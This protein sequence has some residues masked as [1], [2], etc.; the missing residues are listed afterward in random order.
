MFL[1]W[2][3]YII[4]IIGGIEYE[5]GTTSLKILSISLFSATLAC[6]Y[7]NCILIP[8]K[9]DKTLLLTTIAGAATNLLLNFVF[10]PKLGINGAALTTLIGE[11]VVC[12][13]A[14]LYSSKLYKISVNIKNIV[15][16]LAGCLIIIIICKLVPM[17]LDNWALIFIIDVFA[18]V[19]AYIVCLIGFKNDLIEQSIKRLVQ[20]SK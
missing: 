5:G 7:A 6:F 9:K 12:V 11:T 4:R 18:S 20:K 14:Y 17:L 13:G 10:I 3:Q 2:S 19:L 16:S 15:S 8:F 1:L